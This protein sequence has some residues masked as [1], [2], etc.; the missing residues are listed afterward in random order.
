[1]KKYFCLFSGSGETTLRLY[2]TD[3]K[4][5]EH[6]N[7]NNSNSKKQKKIHVQVKI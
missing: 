3:G 7:N 1:M 5:Y 6:K 2:L 4:V